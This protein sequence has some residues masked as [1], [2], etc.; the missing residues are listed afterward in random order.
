MSNIKNL[1]LLPSVNNF[2]KILSG[3]N[4]FIIP[5]EYYI[6]VR[7][8]LCSALSAGNFCIVT[9]AVLLNMP[10]LKFCRSVEVVNFNNNDIMRS[11]MKYHNLSFHE[12]IQLNFESKKFFKKNYL[13]SQSSKKFISQ[14]V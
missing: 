4:V 1:E 8:R 2:E 10:E 12:K 6:G 7:T 11:I 14:I 5:T 9:Q 3:M 13:Y